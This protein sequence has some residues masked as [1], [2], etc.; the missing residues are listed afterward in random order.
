MEYILHKI[1]KE[2]IFI[3]YSLY[4]IDL[5]KEFFNNS[6]NSVNIT[7]EIT[8]LNLNKSI[9]NNN[10]YDFYI[11]EIKKNYSDI[12]SYINYQINKNFII[13]K[14]IEFTDSDIE[15]TDI[16]NKLTDSDITF[17]SDMNYGDD[18]NFKN[19]IKERYSTQLNY[20]K[21]NFN[22]VKFRTEIS[23]SQ[24]LTE[25]FDRLFDDLN[26][27]NLL[28]SNEIIEIDDITNN[29]NI[30]NILN[31]TKIK[32]KKI[33]EE[34]LSFIQEPF[35]EF[36]V[37]FTKKNN[38][39]LIIYWKFLNEYKD[40]LNFRNIIY[41]NNLSEIKNYTINN[42]KQLLNDFNS[43]LFNNLDNIIN[44]TDNYDYFSINY[45]QIYNNYYSILENSFELYMSKIENLKQNNLFY[46]IPKI[47]IN[48]IFLEKRKNIEYII[49]QFSKKFDF[50]S[51]GFKYDLGEEFDLYLKT[52]FMNYEFNNSNKYFEFLENN[53][54]I[55]IEKLENELFTIKN[56]TMDKFN[57]IFDNYIEKIKNI[58]NYVEN[59]YIEKLKINKSIC[60][61]ALSD[62]YINLSNYLNNTNITDS[63]EFIINNCTI[64]GIINSL[65]NNS[66]NNTCL[67]ISEI[68]ETLYYDKF[69]ILFTD[70][71]NNNFYNYSYIILENFQEEY[72]INLKAIITNISDIILLNIIDENYLYNFIK[73]Y[74]IQN[75]SFEINIDDYR[76]YFE[77]IED[78]NFYV[79]NL[80]EP[81]YKNLMY[82]IL[83]EAFNISYI[84]NINIYITNEIMDRINALINDK[85]NIFINYFIN[86]LDYDF[87][88]YSFLLDEM[89]ELGNSSKKS[90]I[91]L[92]SKIP[93]K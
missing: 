2:D 25:S 11:E 38:D 43:T 28:D 4:K 70:C 19:C 30:L 48:D 71:Q 16:D 82:N 34:F 27:N 61:N 10:N 50:D 32:S 62:L 8:N 49:N 69:Y 64:E 20:S 81:E 90:I 21:Y 18:P 51:I 77:D 63:E 1:N 66:Y 78:F 33:K 67:N 75:K 86:K 80:R 13:K 47:I 40:V 12:I 44:I 91:N 15:I 54:I 24:K 26:C 93:K 41:N 52:Y 58:N 89:D 29:K 17:A 84:N 57:L 23:N 85:F 9:L 14:C 68:N 55:Y 65:F 88:Y 59:N 60:Y 3:E 39:L 76:T 31:E 53:S 92:F 79:N 72:E 73:N 5:I 74:Y 36:C 45:T 83:I 7:N 22:V 35:D 42:I 6:L 46:S 37:E 56:N 87:E